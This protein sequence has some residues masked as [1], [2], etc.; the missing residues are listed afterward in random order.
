MSPRAACRLESLGFEKIYDY[1]GGIGDWR[2]GGLS[3][4]GA[5]SDIPTIGDATR[6][7]APTCRLTERVGDVLSRVR[8][9]EWDECVVT[10]ANGVVLGRLRGESWEAEPERVVEEAMEDGPSTVRPHK[11][12]E[13]LFERMRERGVRRVVVTSPEG[14]LIGILRQEDAEELL[15]DPGMVEV[16]QDCEGCP[17][18]WKTIHRGAA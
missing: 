4:E 10:T 16:W 9:A 8:E 1:V 5:G 6:G 12:L 2:A 18:Q 7:D 17:G 13:P 14:R 15:T 3:T 11:P